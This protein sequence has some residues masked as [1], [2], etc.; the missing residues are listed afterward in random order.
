[1]DSSRQ[2]ETDLLNM[3]KEA[4]RHPDLPPLNLSFSGRI[5]V[6]HVIGRF[7]QVIDN[8]GGVEECP[9]VI[10]EGYQALRQLYPLH[11]KTRYSAENKMR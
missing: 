9:L 1:M 5:L 8:Y 2:A 6:D 10:R 11:F 7:G 4:T 3:V